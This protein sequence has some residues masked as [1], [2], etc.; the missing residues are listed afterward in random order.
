MILQQRLPAHWCAAS[1]KQA[2]RGTTTIKRCAV[3]ENKKGPAMSPS[4]FDNA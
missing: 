2:Q 4:L 1:P 3:C